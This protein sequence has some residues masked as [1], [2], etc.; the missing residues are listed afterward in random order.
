M[1]HETTAGMEKRPPAPNVV[2]GI[3]R[4]GESYEF[5]VGTVTKR[6]QGVSGQSISVFAT[7]R[8]NESQLFVTSGGGLQIVNEDHQMVQAQTHHPVIPYAPIAGRT[9]ISTEANKLLEKLT[10][11][12]M[13]RAWGERTFRERQRIATAAVIFA[14][15]FDSRAAELP[16]STGETEVQR[17]LMTL[18]SAVVDEFAQQEEISREDATSFL[19]EVGTRDLVLE[20]NEVLGAWEQDPDSSLDER[21]SKAVDARQ[22]KSIWARHFRSG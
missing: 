15:E 4:V 3:F 17:F 14:Q 18:M 7:R 9:I 5:Q 16:E 20:F 8:Y 22:D 13:T 11:E 10:E 21:L 19:S 2:A 12:T 1:I 6:H